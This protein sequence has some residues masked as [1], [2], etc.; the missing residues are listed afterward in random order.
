MIPY[1]NKLLVL[2]ETPSLERKVYIQAQSPQPIM[3]IME[4]PFLSKFFMS[5][6]VASF[7]DT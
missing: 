2:L 5:L 6:L 1:F 4:S 3:S 7:V